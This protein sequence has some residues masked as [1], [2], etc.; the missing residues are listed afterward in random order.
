MKVIKPWGYYI[1][2]YEEPH[3]LVKKI[4][5][6]A[7]QSLSLQRHFKR[8][9]TWMIVQGVATITLHEDV[10]TLIAGNSISIPKRAWHRLENKG[11]LVLEVVE[12]Q[13]GEPDEEDIERREDNYGRVS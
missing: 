13:F 7:G 5:V 9:E 12:V 6:E 11:N 10:Y 3:T 2:L 1:N 8:S 4:I